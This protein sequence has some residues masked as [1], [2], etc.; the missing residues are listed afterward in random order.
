MD[1]RVV[2]RV[3]IVYLYRVQTTGYRGAHYVGLK[4]S[5]H[6]ADH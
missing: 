4:R 1:Y 2:G 6:Q 5:E 3:P